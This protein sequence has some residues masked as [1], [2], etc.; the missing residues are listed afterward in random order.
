MD[1]GERVLVA[2]G[3][4]WPLGRQREVRVA[5]PQVWD[6]ESYG[7]PLAD[8]ERRQRAEL[9]P[10][11]VVLGARVV[12]ALLSAASRAPGAAAARTLRFRVLR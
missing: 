5:E 12:R 3:K 6:D 8:G 11:V 10:R 7:S 2:V 4:V 1:R 9:P